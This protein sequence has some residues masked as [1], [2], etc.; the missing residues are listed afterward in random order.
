[1]DSGHRLHAPENMDTLPVGWTLASEKT[2]TDSNTDS[3]TTDGKSPKDFLPP[4][5]GSASARTS[6][7]KV[8]HTTDQPAC[9]H[10]SRSELI[11]IVRVLQQPIGLTPHPPSGTQSARIPGKLSLPSL[12]SA[13]QPGAAAQQRKRLERQRKEDTE[14]FRKAF[15]VIDKDGSGMVEPDEIVSCL[16]VFG[17]DV[18]RKRF[19]QVFKEADRDKSDSLDQDEFIDMMLRVTE[20]TR[21][22]KAKRANALSRKLRAGAAKVALDQKKE[23]EQ[24]RFHGRRSTKTVVEEG[25]QW[26]DQALAQHRGLADI[27]ASRKR[28]QRMALGVGLIEPE[29][30]PRM[31]TMLGRRVVKEERKRAAED[32]RRAARPDVAMAALDTFAT[33]FG[34]APAPKKSTSLKPPSD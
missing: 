26:M 27:Y 19:W 23:K 5:G 24:Q 10:R 30:D 1:M 2:A 31:R 13:T 6:G 7:S 8:R 25:S 22:A 29:E 14:I 16:K 20:K 15:S 21:A 18:D 17:K 9:F 4:I 3:T 32:Q 34:N 28:L 11:R 33:M 12:R